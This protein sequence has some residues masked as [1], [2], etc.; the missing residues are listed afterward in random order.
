MYFTT[1]EVKS[2]HLLSRGGSI[3]APNHVHTFRSSVN[4]T[5]YVCNGCVR[6]IHYLALPLR[7]TGQ[8]RNVYCLFFMCVCVCVSISFSFS[9]L[10]S[11]SMAD[12]H[13][14]EHTHTE[15]H[16]LSDTQA[17]KRRKSKSQ[18]GLTLPDTS[19]N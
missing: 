10:S 18:I 17:H 4:I 8:I 7:H 12:Q 19:V 6:S 15:T 2:S 11:L 9:F 5:S 14:R 1:G 3:P 13:T 16:V